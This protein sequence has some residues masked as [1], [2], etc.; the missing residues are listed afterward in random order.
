ME[1]VSVYIDGFNLYFGLCSKGWRR[2]LWLD[3]GKLA[4]VILNQNQSLI[5]TK[6]FTALVRD[7]P[8]KEKRQSTYLQALKE[9]E[10]VL[11]FLGRYQ[12]KTKKC[13]ICKSSWREYEEKMSDVKIASELLRD[14]FLNK[15]DTAILISADGDLQ[16]PID[17]IKEEFPDKKIVIAFP[18]DRDNPHLK[19]IVDSFFR[20]GRGRISKCQLPASI[21]KSDGFVLVR[22]K[23]WN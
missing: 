4:S 5:D 12:A 13:K 15:F 23:E 18:P 20:I 10:N 1:R 21:K 19:N 9:M 3:V 8:A 14:G 11:I 16:P 7:D 17:I 2:Y 6:Y 22:P